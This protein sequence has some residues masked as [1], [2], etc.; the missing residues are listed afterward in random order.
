[1]TRRISDSTAITAISLIIIGIL[2]CVFRAGMLNIIVTVIG[3]LLIA[4]GLYDVF[5]RKET[6]LGIIAGV[7]GIVVIIFGWT[8]AEAALILTG[9]IAI[10]YGIFIF[11]KNIGTVK[12]GGA[13]AKAVAVVKPLVMIIFGILLIVAYNVMAD[14]MMI[15]LGIFSIIGGVLM[16]AK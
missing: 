8:I 16:L 14:A 13:F 10:I 11:V 2:C 9:I 1:M 6:A 15:A 3:V 4:I 5:V 12:T 7:A